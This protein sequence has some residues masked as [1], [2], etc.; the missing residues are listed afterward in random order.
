MEHRIEISAF[1]GP[2][3]M[4]WVPTELPPPGPGE[5]RLRH[6][7]VG[8]NYIDTYHRRGLYPVPLPAP[9]GVEGAGVVEAVGPGVS[10]FAPGDRACTFGPLPGSYATARNLPAA[11]LLHTPATVSDEL[12]ATALLK[13]CT[14]EFLVERCARVEPGESV[15]VHAAAGGVGLLLVQWLRHLGARVIGTVST[16]EKAA[17]AHAAGAEAV[18]VTQTPWQGL[19]GPAAIAPQVRALTGGA[20]VRVSFDGVG[21][22]TWEASLDSTARCG[23][24]VSYGNASA[25]VSGVAL[26]VLAAKGSLFVTRPTLYDYYREPAE[27][28]AGAERMFALFAAG[29]LE[30]TIGQ[31]FALAEAAEAHRALEGRRTVGSTLLVP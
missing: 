11:Q 21:M 9:L 19:T 6:T 16:P 13:G 12:A 7:A 20:G 10:D 14:A 15:L 24:I 2:E 3:G 22:D 17:L 26:G 1:G 29:V 25:P 18:I 31:R 27:R 28:A 4:Q 8:L 23:L 5:V 30:V